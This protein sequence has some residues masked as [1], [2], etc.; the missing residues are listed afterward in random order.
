MLAMMYLCP[1]GEKKEK[2]KAFEGTEKSSLKTFDDAD[3]L[4]P[5]Y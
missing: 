4:F 2:K 1:K 5:N 3:P